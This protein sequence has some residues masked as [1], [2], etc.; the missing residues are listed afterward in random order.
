[1]DEPWNVGIQTTLDV[2]SAMHYMFS[3][4]QCQ[5]FKPQSN[6]TRVELCQ[7]ILVID[8]NPKWSGGQVLIS[9]KI[10]WLFLV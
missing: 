8:M 4:L 1:M 7:D 6:Q 5:F 10:Q 2:E 3:S 9:K